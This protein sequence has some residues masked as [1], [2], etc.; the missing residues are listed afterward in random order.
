MTY[1]PYWTDYDLHGQDR[2]KAPEE[3]W[4]FVGGIVLII[5]SIIILLDYILSP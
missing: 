1:R 2:E 4:S 3:F 5:A